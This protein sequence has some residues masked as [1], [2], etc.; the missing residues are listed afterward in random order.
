MGLEALIGCARIYEA[1]EPF[2]KLKHYCEESSM[3]NIPPLQ[4]RCPTTSPTEDVTSEQSSWKACRHSEL[5]FMN[6]HISLYIGNG[7]Y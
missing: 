3:K 2:L 7:K 4:R 5:C 6:I 1:D